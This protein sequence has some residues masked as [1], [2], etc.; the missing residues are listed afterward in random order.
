MMWRCGAGSSQ[1]ITPIHRICRAHDRHIEM[2]YII[3][4]VSAAGSLLTPLLNYVE[5]C[6]WCCDVDHVITHHFDTPFM[7]YYNKSCAANRSKI[8]WRSIN[9]YWISCFLNEES[10]RMRVKKKL[11]TY[12]FV[13]IRWNNCYGW[14]NYV[15]CLLGKPVSHAIR[16]SSVCLH[17]LALS[18]LMLLAAVRLHGLFKQNIIFQ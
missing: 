1:I 13:F 2:I 10:H 6:L 18:F 9:Y 5:D 16:L 3:F 15:N 11:N 14:D 7:D 8:K 4:V 12:L 17:L